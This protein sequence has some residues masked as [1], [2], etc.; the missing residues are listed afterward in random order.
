MRCACLNGLH[1][2]HSPGRPNSPATMK[3]PD[4]LRDLRHRLEYAAVRTLAALAR[5]LPLNL[6]VRA[7]ALMWGVLA[8]R[9][10]PKRHRRALANLRIA[11]PS[12]SEA[13]LRAIC[14][15]HWQNLGRVVAETVQIDRVLSDPSRIE[16]PDQ[17]LLDRY[18]NKLGP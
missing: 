1:H 4:S 9:L 13:E 14:K 6:A 10:N 12:K 16:I 5:L 17:H 7:S 3:P 15:A 18:R 2:G 8:P 11:F